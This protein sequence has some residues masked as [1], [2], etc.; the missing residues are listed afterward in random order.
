[1]EADRPDPNGPGAATA[2]AATAAAA[3]GAAT[4]G[5]PQPREPQDGDGGL[6]LPGILHFIQYEWG[7]FQAEKY[8]WEAERD[9]LRVSG[10]RDEGRAPGER[11]RGTSSG[12]GGE[13]VGERDELRVSEGE[14]RAPGERGRGTSSGAVTQVV[15]LDGDQP[16]SSHFDVSVTFLR[17]L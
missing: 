11:G 1:M 4:A 8:R 2:A 3:T 10:E 9:E 15:P 14:G 16:A 13:R 7:R 6:S 17:D 12:C 5:C